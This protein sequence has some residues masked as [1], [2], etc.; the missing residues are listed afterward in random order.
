MYIIAIK[1]A[2][3]RFNIRLNNH[4]KDTKDPNI[5]LAC[6]HF[7]QQVHIFKSHAIFLIIDKLVNT[8]SSKNMWTLNTMRKLLD[9]DTKNLSSIQTKPRTQQIEKKPLMLPFQVHFYQNHS[10]QITLELRWWHKIPKSI[11][12]HIMMK[13]NMHETLMCETCFN[14]TIKP[15]EQCETLCSGVSF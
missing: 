13:W 10:S 14:S 6:R 5:I 1:K 12:C 4:R 9:P 2:E 15:Q 7:Q 8:L 11:W 3:T